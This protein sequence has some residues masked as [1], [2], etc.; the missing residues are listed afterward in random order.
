MQRR[1]FSPFEIGAVAAVITGVGILLVPVLALGNNY[2]LG[3]LVHRRRCQLNLR[4]IMLGMLQYTQDYDE[5]FP[6]SAASSGSPYGWAESLMP[7]IKSEQV[8]QCPA[9]RHRPSRNP[10]KAGYTDYWYNRNLASVGQSAV[11]YIAST[12]TLGDGDGGSRAST[13]RYAINNLPKIWLKLPGSPARR[14]INRG[15]YAFADGHIKWLSPEVITTA[16]PQGKNYT[17]AP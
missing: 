17:F 4:S 11:S 2:N 12:L 7:Y 10:R 14:H 3:D 6:V 1:R 15:N 8:F 9:E 13:A 16:P 5:K